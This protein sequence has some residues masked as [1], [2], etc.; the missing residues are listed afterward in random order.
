MNLLFNKAGQGYVLPNMLYDMAG[1]VAHPLDVERAVIQWFQVTPFIPS[2]I[3]SRIP[4]QAV[5]NSRPL[6]FGQYFQI[7]G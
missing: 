3:V 7:I 5:S 4:T 2:N 6:A 1:I